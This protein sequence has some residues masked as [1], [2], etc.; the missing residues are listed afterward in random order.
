MNVIAAIQKHRAKQGSLPFRPGMLQRK[1]SCSYRAGGGECAECR[2]TQ[3]GLRRRAT[4]SLDMTEI[5]PIVHEVLRSPG[6]PLDKQT[7]EFM[8]PRFGHDF[9]RVRVH[10]DAKASEIEHQ[11]RYQYGK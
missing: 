7:Q 3:H 6:Q 8:E 2:S 4:G 5:P 11:K 10:T 9:S 1:C